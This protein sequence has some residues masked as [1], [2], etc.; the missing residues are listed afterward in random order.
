MNMGTEKWARPKP[1]AHGLRRGAWYPVVNEMNSAM[2]VLDVQKNNVPVPRD[3]VVVVEEP[4][5]QWTVV[6]WQESQRGAQRAS[7]RNQS[8]TYA[9]CP[10]CRS[11]NDLQP[12]DAPRLRCQVCDGSYDV[13]WEHV[14]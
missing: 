7:E 3:M 1:G 9:V 5:R 2:V 8:L 10:N 14:G 6:Q 12:A 4:P 13:D 11:R